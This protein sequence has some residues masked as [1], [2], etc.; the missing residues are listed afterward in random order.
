MMAQAAAQQQV[1]FCV[2]VGSCVGVRL[3]MDC[4]LRAASPIDGEV[5]ERERERE[6][7]KE[8]YSRVEG[9]RESK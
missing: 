7:E 6:R 1:M 9:T 2:R 5:R 3:R 8:R 4:Y